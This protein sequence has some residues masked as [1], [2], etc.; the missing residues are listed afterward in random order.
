MQ[1]QLSLTRSFDFIDFILL[2]NDSMAV[3]KEKYL[4][5][6]DI[7]KL[8][9]INKAKV[10]KG[11]NLVLLNDKYLLIGTE[12]NAIIF[13]NIKNTNI[14]SISCSYPLK[15]IVIIGETTNYNLS[16]KKS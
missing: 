13:E 10:N 6:Y 15:N 1:Y 2:K 4:E 5:F 16:K 7:H 9:M 14:K 3:L 12:K 8:N 11:I